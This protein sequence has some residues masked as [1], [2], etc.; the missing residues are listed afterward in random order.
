MQSMKIIEMIPSPAATE[1]IKTDHFRSKS[2]V[3]GSTFGSQTSG[4]RA[5]TGDHPLS[6]SMNYL[7]AGKLKKKMKNNLERK[8]KFR[9]LARGIKKCYAVRSTVKPCMAAPAKASLQSLAPRSPRRLTSRN[10]TSFRCSATRT[11]R[12][13]WLP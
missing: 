11:N 3:T 2:R 1:Q 9:P 4:I 6:L 13:V 10:R 8:I 5:N 12:M 7:V